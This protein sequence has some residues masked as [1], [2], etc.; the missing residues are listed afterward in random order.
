MKQIRCNRFPQG[1]LRALTMSYDDGRQYDERLSKLFSD[2]GIRAT[3]HLNS[4]FWDTPDY[5]T[6]QQAQTLYL[7]HEISLHTLTHPHMPDLPDTLILEEMLEDKKNLEAAAGYIVRGMSYPYGQVDDR[8]IAL[9]RA[10]GMH[11]SR[12]VVSTRNFTLP[13]DFMRWDPTCHHNDDLD[14]LWDRFE[15]FRKDQPNLFYI[16]GHSYEFDRAN[17]WDKI[18]RFVEKASGHD[19]IWYATN[20]EIYDYVTAVRHLEFSCDRT[21]VLN[22]ASFPVWIE[23]DGEAV[24]I[25]A[26]KLMRI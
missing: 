20:I 14:G 21:M 17:N 4:G 12:T 13:Q 6:S 9:C 1:R 5:I 16:W 15:N 26:G 24:Q 11:Y 25:P 7:D 8:I 23:V 19:D 22:P 10:C 2:A 18:E 3:F